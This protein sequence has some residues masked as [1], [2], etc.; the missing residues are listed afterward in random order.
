MILIR[1]ENS[2]RYEI[3]SCML[4]DKK[5]LRYNIIFHLSQFPLGISIYHLHT[6]D[7]GTTELALRWYVF[8]HLEEAKLDSYTHCKFF[9]FFPCS[10]LG[11]CGHFDRKGKLSI[12]FP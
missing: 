10:S 5:L 11:N 7:F 3:K 6:V 8:L 4:F 12:F 9:V 1:Y 2:V